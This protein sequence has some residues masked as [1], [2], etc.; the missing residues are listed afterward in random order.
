MISLYMLQ[1]KC[2]WRSL[3]CACRQS[4]YDDACPGRHITVATSEMVNKVHD[5]VMDNSHVT[6]RFVTIAVGISI[7]R[8]HSNLK[9]ACRQSIYDD[10]YPGRHTTVATSEMVNKVHDTI[11]DDNQ[12]TKRYVTIAVEIS[13]E[14]IHPISSDNLAMRKISARCAPRLLTTDQKQIRQTLSH[15]YFNI[16]GTDPSSFLQRFVTMDETLIK[17]QPKQWDTFVQ[18]YQRRQGLF[19]RLERL[20]HQQ[21]GLLMV[22]WR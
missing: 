11:M 3:K 22:F 4:L 21:S 12:V 15:A 13:L 17:Q 8:I 18:P 9:C 20:W 1:W 10:A 19:H 2:G 6:K 16:E 14:R 7:E 5:T